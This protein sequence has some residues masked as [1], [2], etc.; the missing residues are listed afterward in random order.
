MVARN[1]EWKKWF[2]TSGLPQS[3]A[4]FVKVI[5]LF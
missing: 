5:K 2:T 4:E 1:K 3:Q